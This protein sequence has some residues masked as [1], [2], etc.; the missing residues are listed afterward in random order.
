[1]RPAIAPLAAA[2]I[3]AGVLLAA[4]AASAQGGPDQP[5]SGSTEI[6][7][8][9]LDATAAAMQQVTALQRSYQQKIQTAAPADKERI[10]SEGNDALKKAVTDHGLSVEEYNSI[11]TVAQNDPNVR[12]KLL[13]RLHPPQQQ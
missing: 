12:A 10:A 8:Q 11:L 13:Q 2:L 4:P 1:M 3:G 5:L 6:S 9:K 7:D